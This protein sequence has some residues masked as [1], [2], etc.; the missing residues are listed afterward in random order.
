VL[1][2]LLLLRKKK[3]DQKHADQYASGLELVTQET[4][5]YSMM[6]SSSSRP[7]SIIGRPKSGINIYFLRKF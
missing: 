3:K 7:S 4:G 5:N 6:P 2:L 1:L